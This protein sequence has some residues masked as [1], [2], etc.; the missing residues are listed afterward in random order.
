MS[1]ESLRHPI[2]ECL[3]QVDGNISN[4]QGMNITVFNYTNNKSFIK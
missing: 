1:A 2:T 3:R 4:T